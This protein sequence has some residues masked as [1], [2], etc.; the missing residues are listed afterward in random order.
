MKK[1]KNMDNIPVDLAIRLIGCGDPD[2]I[3]KYILKTGNSST[4]PSNVEE[5]N[6]PYRKD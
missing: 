2:N 1:E 4:D 5:K 6:K 3:S